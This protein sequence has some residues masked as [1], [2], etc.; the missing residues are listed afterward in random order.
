MNVATGTN[1]TGRIKRVL[2][3]SPHGRRTVHVSSAGLTLSQLL[4]RESLQLNTRCGERGLCDGCVV[5][6]VKGRLIHAST[7]ATIQAHGPGVVVRGCEHLPTD[8]DEP[9]QIH[10]PARSMLAHEPQVVTSFRL[11][12]ARAQ[13]PLWRRVV[14]RGCEADSRLPTEEKIGREA[15][16]LVGASADAVRIELGAL[17]QLGDAPSAEQWVA[18]IE[19]RDSCWCVTGL[20]PA[21]APEI[22]PIGA[23]VDLGTTTVVV[24]L[25]DLR[26][27][28]VIGQAAGFNRQVHL[29]DDV[30]TRINLCSTDKAMLDRLEEAVIRQTLRPLLCEALKAASDNAVDPPSQSTAASHVPTTPPSPPDRRLTTVVLAGNTT[31]LHI[32]AGVDPTPMGVSPFRPVFTNHQVT[33]ARQLR[34]DTPTGDDPS[35][36]L[37][38]SAAAYIGADLT[39]GVIAS[40]LVYDDGPSILLDVG[41]NGEIILKHHDKLLGCATA[42]GPAFEG[43]RLAS[44]IRAGRGAIEAIRL[45]RDPFVIHTTVIGNTKPIGLCGSAYIDLLAHARRIELISPTG[46]YNPDAIGA[47]AG[48]HL[49]RADVHGLSLRLAKASG[50][51]DLIVSEP[52]IASLMQAKA[53]I[54]AGIL[55]LL[56]LTG[57]SP[58]DVRRVYLAGGFGMHINLRNAIAIGL[59]PGFAEAQI[60]VVGNSSLA[61]AYLSLLDRGALRAIEDVA[62][63][64]ETIELNTDPDFE[65]CYIDQLSLP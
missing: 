46:R 6:L 56:K 14:L 26:D 63:R 65:S 12:V 25:V 2:V 24:L 44:G 4:R 59:L 55:T 42:A 30:L 61:G 27:G 60:Q 21:P 37:L 39:A 8:D 36:H 34:L 16:R 10:V 52:D 38:P 40:G 45:D 53:A 9:C 20:V 11:N 5:E 48:Q 1:A 58:F 51:R 57:M 43:A 62:R 13:D 50:A 32:A 19:Q 18:T 15:A 49:V 28:S 54:A 7:G 41:T 23:A 64:I 29:G 3:D 17:R 47:A 22:Q 31:M 33:T 35:V